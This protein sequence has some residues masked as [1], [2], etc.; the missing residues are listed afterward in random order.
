MRTLPHNAP[1]WIT[2]VLVLIS[3]ICL[4]ASPDKSVYDTTQNWIGHF[5]LRSETDNATLSLQYETARTQ[6]RA[7]LRQIDTELDNPETS[8]EEGF[9]LLRERLRTEEQLRETEAEYQLKFTKMRY[10][11]AIEIIKMLYEKILSMDHHFSSLKAQQDLLKIS[12]PHHYPAFQEV[13]TLLEDKMKKKFNFTMPEL[14]R[15]NPYL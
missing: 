14:M 11:K 13:R 8:A 6:M 4:Q 10:R 9:G 12:N 7:R 5:L 1:V 15:S 3:G 2:V